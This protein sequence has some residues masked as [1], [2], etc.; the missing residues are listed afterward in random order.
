MRSTNKSRSARVI[1]RGVIGLEFLREAAVLML[2]VGALFSGLMQVPLFRSALA[3]AETAGR[4]WSIHAAFLDAGGRELWIVRRGQGLF[5]WSVADGSEEPVLPAQYPMGGVAVYSDEEDTVIAT[6]RY[7]DIVEIWRNGRVVVEHTLNES[8]NLVA[9][10]DIAERGR[11]IVAV[12]ESGHVCVWRRQGD[13]FVLRRFQIACGLTRVELSP[14]GRF[15]ASVSHSKQVVICDLQEER[16]H[17]QWESPHDHCTD[18]A[19]SP[20]GQTLASV[21]FGGQLC[22]WD[23]AT[24]ELRWQCRADVHDAAAVVFSTSGDRLITGGFESRVRVWD[25]AAGTL[26][27]EFLGHK[28]GVRALVCTA[29]GGRVFS[30]GLD[31]Q[32]MSWPL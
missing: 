7:D 31:G 2:V 10:V 25:A 21:G 16:I 24:Q 30:C 14:D 15:A 23:V 9:S 1:R 22:V 8:S 17:A 19:W 18:F 26:V 13:D 4:A 32:V 28:H 5:R 27:T 3:P 29:D 12:C 20:D 11:L 6:T